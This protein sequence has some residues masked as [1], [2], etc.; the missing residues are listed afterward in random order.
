MSGE[1]N[2]QDPNNLAGQKRHPILAGM[3]NAQEER[4]I[5]E[6]TISH[7]E[8]R[9]PKLAKEVRAKLNVSGL[10]WLIHYYRRQLMM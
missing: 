4:L 6:V 3:M 10:S 5:D 8:M 2:Q 7:I 9:N 1:G